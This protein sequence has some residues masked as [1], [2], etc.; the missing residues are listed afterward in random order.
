MRFPSVISSSIFESSSLF[1]GENLITGLITSLSSE[2][3]IISDCEKP[4]VS[5][6]FMKNSY[7][8][9]F[10]RTLTTWLRW[11][12]SY[13]FEIYNHLQG[14][15]CFSCRLM[16][17]F[18]RENERKSW[19]WGRHS[20]TRTDLWDIHLIVKSGPQ[21]DTC[22]YY[23]TSSHTCRFCA[24]SPYSIRF[25]NGNAVDATLVNKFSSE[26]WQKQM[27]GIKPK[28]TRNAAA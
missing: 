21:V 28:I 25:A 19:V 24:R 12:T 13:L 1:T 15:S 10:I 17:L 7:S 26:S 18:S 9:L 23:A 6:C 5:H 4:Y 22:S 2:V 3:R 20:P 11:G 27:A 14:K 8:S 16:T